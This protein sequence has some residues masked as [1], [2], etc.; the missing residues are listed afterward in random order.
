MPL[1]S[2]NLEDRVDQRGLADSRAAG[3]DQDLQEQSEPERVPRGERSN[4]EGHRDF[5]ADRGVDVVLLDD[6][7]CIDL[8][9]RFIRARP[10]LW[11]EDI[12]EEG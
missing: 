10:E 12:A 5:L 9:A 4:F 7:D 11:N 1:A 6:P 8:M 3:N 2:R